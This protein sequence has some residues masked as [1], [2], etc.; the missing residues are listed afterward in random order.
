MNS[1]LAFLK[2]LEK[3]IF[4]KT[5]KKTRKIKAHRPIPM[6]LLLLSY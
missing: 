3:G 4:Q 5:N 2:N 1:K 6:I